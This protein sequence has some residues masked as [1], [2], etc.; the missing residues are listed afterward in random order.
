MPSGSRKSDIT[1]S[2]NAQAPSVTTLGGLGSRSTNILQSERTIGRRRV[3]R[4]SVSCSRSSTHSQTAPV[5]STHILC[6]G[7]KVLTP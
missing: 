4:H 2:G 5:G 6:D 3:F 7:T 1:V